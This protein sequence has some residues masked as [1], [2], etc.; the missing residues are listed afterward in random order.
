MT[1]TLPEIRPEVRSFLSGQPKKLLIGGQWVEAASGKSFETLNPATG[2]VLAKVCEGDKEDVDRAVKA[3]RASLAVW[4]K[5]PA[6]EKARILW[7]TA[8]LLEKHADELAELETLDNGKT[9]REARKGDLVMAIEL[10]RYYAGWATKLHGDTIP[11]SM[12]YAPQL[13]ERR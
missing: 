11:V 2:E 10:F 12:P 8:D 5:V 4:A 6:S 3:A 13:H 9:I 1:A 7:K